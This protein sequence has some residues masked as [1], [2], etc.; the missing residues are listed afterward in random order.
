MRKLFKISKNLEKKTSKR[1]MEKILA[2]SQDPYHFFDR[3]TGSDGFKLRVGDYR[4]IADIDESKK[5]IF[6]LIIAHRKNI[7]RKWWVWTDH[8]I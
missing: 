7:Y 6:I 8:S 5:E 1:I 2:A 4:V 3:L